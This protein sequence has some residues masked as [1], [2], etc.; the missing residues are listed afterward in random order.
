VLGALDAMHE[1]IIAHV[2]SRVRL[3][4]PP[5]AAGVAGDGIGGVA[6]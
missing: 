4:D 2:C 6:G 1:A 3:V 5:A